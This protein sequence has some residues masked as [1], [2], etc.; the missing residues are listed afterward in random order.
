[1]SLTHSQPGLADWPIRGSL[2]I[3]AVAQG[4]HVRAVLVDPCAYLIGSADGSVTGDEDIDVVR[5]AREQSQPNDV[6]LDR[7]VGAGEVV[8]HRNEDIREHVA[9]DENPAFLDQQGC[10]ARGMRRVL[11]DPDSRA[12]PGNLC[13]SGRQTGDE[14]ERVQRDLLGDSGGNPSAT[15]AFQFAS[16]RR[17]RI[18][19]AQRAV[20]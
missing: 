1:M 8:E 17:S 13:R 12:I 2:G 4:V 19:A 14:A 6:V 7:V 18:L 11:D 10:M 20:P 3:M 9:G 16:D 5:H 15:R